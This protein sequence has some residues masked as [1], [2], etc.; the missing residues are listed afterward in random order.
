MTTTENWIEVSVLVKLRTCADYDSR[1]SELATPVAKPA[2][3]A[4]SKNIDR[5]NV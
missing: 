3:K 5:Q 1:G 4:V 2:K